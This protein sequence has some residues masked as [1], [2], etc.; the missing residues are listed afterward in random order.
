MK[1]FIRNK[2]I[3]LRGSSEILDENETPIYM[4]KGKLISPT[5]KK[6]LMDLDGNLIYTIRNKYFKFL[7]HSALIYDRDGNKIAKVKQSFWG[8][9]YTILGY[10]EEIEIEGKFFSRESRILKNG[11]SIGTITRDYSLISDH[12]TLEADK[13]NIEFLIALVVA[14]DIIRDKQERED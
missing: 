11:E 14:M 4:V 10:P 13:E 6:K 12:F 9:R 3:S 7:F 2:L 5:R 1:V 8:T